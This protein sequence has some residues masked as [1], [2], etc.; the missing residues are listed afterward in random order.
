MFLLQGDHN[1]D[2]QAGRGGAYSVQGDLAPLARY[3]TA[4]T[5]SSAVS[6]ANQPETP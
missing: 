4:I 2:P 5:T 3:T 1:A 6:T